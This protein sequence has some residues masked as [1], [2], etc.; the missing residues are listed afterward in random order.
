MS[1]DNRLTNG[2][3]SLINQQI[4]FDR[5]T[6]MNSHLKRLEEIEMGKLTKLKLNT[7]R[8]N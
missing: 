6:R 5:K 8:S 3:H 1:F 4:N 7:N 2:R